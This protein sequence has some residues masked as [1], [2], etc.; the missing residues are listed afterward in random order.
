MTAIRLLFALALGTAMACAPRGSSTV[1]GDDTSAEGELRDLQREWGVALTQRD[2]A[3]F[4]RVLAEDF[5]SGGAT[6]ARFLANVSNPSGAV[7]ERVA[8]SDVRV[9]LYGETAV[10]TALGEYSGQRGAQPFTE[11]SRYLRVFVRRAGRWQAVAGQSTPVGG[12]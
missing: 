1:R 3:F 5:E 11:R 7:Y 6:K 4:S 8:V 12:G 9:R 10:V 2:T